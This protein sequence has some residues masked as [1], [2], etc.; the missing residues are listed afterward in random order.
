MIK[1]LRP[2][3]LIQATTNFVNNV[4]GHDL[5]ELSSYNFENIVEQEIGPQ[6]P[7]A[8][9]SVP[10]Y[11]ASYRV[12]NLV[13]TLGIKCTSIA[14]GSPEGFNL[15]DQ[16]INQSSRSGQWV[17]LKN[18]HLAPGWLTQ[19]EKKL[20]TL[21][22][23]PN[24]RLFLTMEINP[25]VP[26]NILRQSRILM[27]EPPP[28][29]K[30]NILETLRNLKIS[31]GPVE[32][33]RLYFILAWLHA[34]IQERLRYSPIGWSKIY[35]FNDSDQ[36]SALNMIDKWI[37][38]I[39]KG[40]SNLDPAT[41]PW[42]A[43]RTLLK[44]SIYGGRIDRDYDQKLLNTFV[45][46]L[47]NERIY[48]N[49]FELVKS[50]DGQP[51]LLIPQCT[52]LEQFI[53]WSENTLPEREP[54]TWLSLPIKAEKVIAISLGNNL[55]NKLRKMKSLSDDDET[56]NVK[57][58]DDESKSQP[59]WM[60]TL[61]ENCEEWLE[62]L[63]KTINKFKPDINSPH[64]PIFRFFKRESE[65]GNRLYVKV[66]NDLMDL[67][68]VC[69]GEIKQTNHLRTLMSELSKGKRMF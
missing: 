69:K 21:N 58:D 22:P 57:N 68:K 43:I 44:Q 53:E 11:D 39:A 52:R 62:C 46:E 27:N 55:L 40:R 66:K 5:T 26:I 16:A 34:I 56:V 50:I 17:L 38:G 61:M 37:N 67:I 59:A 42:E 63:P 13:K 51:S 4:F 7:I 48:E 47:F 64:D 65:I 3:R 30:A 23:T 20:Q 28:G 6:T 24:F 49:D 15:A 18:V 35:E 41:F 12:D 10:G 19:V 54:I 32:K 33:C 36:L 14:M 1:Y 29:I 9:C 25:L 8:L 60:R 45:D 2:D 31:T